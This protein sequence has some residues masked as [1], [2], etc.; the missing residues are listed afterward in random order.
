VNAILDDRLAL[1]VGPTRPL[2]YTTPAVEDRPPHVR[3]ASG[4]TVHAG[5]LYVI[6]DDTSFVA[7][8]DGD[9]VG[10]IAIPYAPEGRRR[11]EK[12]LG[13]KLAKLD[14]EACVVLDG[15]LLAFGSGSLAVVRER[16]VRIRGARVELVEASALYERMWLAVGY[17]LN[18][19]GA[20]IV[21]DELWLFHRGNVGPSDPGPAVVRIALAAM[22]E[23]LAGGRAPALA[24]DRYDL[25][26]I[27]GV[28]LGFTDATTARDGRVFVLLAAEASRDAI[29]DGGVLAARVGV[30]DGGTIR[31]APLVIDGRS[32]KAE[33][34]AF[35]SDPMTV[36]ITIDPD[37]VHVPAPL[38]KVRLIGPW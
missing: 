10:A 17:A 38:C 23:F 37:D 6:Q 22:R 32:P 9:T 21:G 13:N 16:I 28:R 26:S 31:C 1:E 19:E 27:D 33:G 4:I 12:A 30:I 36:W 34:I 3:S 7:V 29:E 24:V 35:T 5:A 8:V 18:L 14:L 25:G 2:V 20:A 15:E 11:F